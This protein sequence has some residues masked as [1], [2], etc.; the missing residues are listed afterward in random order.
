VPL[1][2]AHRPHRRAGHGRPDVGD[3]TLSVPAGA[4]FSF[5]SQALIVDVRGTYRPT[6]FQ[7]LF[8]LQPG[9]ALTNWSVDMTVGYEF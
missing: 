5:G 2:D 6:Y 8:I 9:T 7:Q 1:L 3:N 4:G